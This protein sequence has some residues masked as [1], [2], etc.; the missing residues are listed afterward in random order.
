VLVRIPN[1]V[2]GG[3]M[4]AGY[5]VPVYHRGHDPISGMPLDPQPRLDL[6]IG[7][8]VQPA[9]QW[10]LAVDLSIIDR[11]DLA[12]AATRLP[13]LDGGFDQ[14]QLMVGISRR[15]ELGGERHRGISDPLIQL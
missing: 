2:W 14:I 4:G 13:I 3:W 9:D 15:I 12:M 10:D 6:D 5:A 8:A 7:N 11:G 1:G